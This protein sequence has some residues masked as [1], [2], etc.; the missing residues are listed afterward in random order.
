[1]APN[2]GEILRVH[3]IYV[4]KRRKFQNK[5]EKDVSLIAATTFHEQSRDDGSLLPIVYSD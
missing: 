4:L 5:I 2:R 1:M 3:E